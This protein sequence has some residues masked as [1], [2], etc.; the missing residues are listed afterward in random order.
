MSQRCAV[1]E[2]HILCRIYSKSPLTDT[3]EV[4]L[5]DYGVAA[6]EVIDNGSGIEPENY[7]ALSMWLMML[8]NLSLIHI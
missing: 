6:I 7:A 4:R 3:P 2:R 5:R 8:Q 1:G